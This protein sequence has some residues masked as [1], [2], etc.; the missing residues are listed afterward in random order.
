MTRLWLGLRGRLPL[1]A[2]AF[3][4]D[5]HRRGVLRQFGAVYQFR[6]GRLQDHLAEESRPTP[7][8]SATQS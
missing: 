5:A 1:R 6:H 2:M 3:L 4:D 7:R 8:A